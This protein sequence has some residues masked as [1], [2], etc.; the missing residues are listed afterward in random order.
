MTIIEL[1]KSYHPDFASPD[2]APIGAVEVDYVEP[3]SFGLL[4]YFLPDS[5][6]FIDVVNNQFHPSTVSPLNG[7]PAFNRHG[8]YID[9]STDHEV[10]ITPRTFNS[11]EE[12]TITWLAA[13]NSSTSS[14][15]MFIG[16]PSVSTDFIWMNT[17]GTAIQF[18]RN[19]QNQALSIPSISHDTLIWRSL[20]VQFARTDYYAGGLSAGGGATTQPFDISAIAAGFST[21][22]FDFD[23]QL[24][25]LM[26]HDRPL[27]GAEVIAL[28]EN[29]YSLLK[30]VQNPIYFTPSGAT[31]AA[32]TGTAVPTIT[33]A[34][35]VAGGKTILIT[36]T[37]DTWVAAGATFDAQRQ[38]I[39]NGLDAAASPTNGWNNEV[40]DKEVVTAVVRT[41]STLVTITLTA[42]AGYD[43]AATETITTTIPATAL[44][45]SAGAI[46]GSPTFTVTAVS[47][48]QAAWARGSNVI[49]QVGL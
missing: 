40:R 26:I 8:R 6:S 16:K 37:G 47:G 15:G 13:K 44:V 5:N 38:N 11:G 12:Y 30:P 22:S 35:V 49:I 18:R 27:S 17:S 3:L 42:Q 20:V 46:T 28:H 7:V 43:V 32:I 25:G 10:G 4:N 21:S 24:Q 33:E 9:C 19:N 14:G 34:D 23:G 39:I 1:D 45:T 2:V 31:T 48:F 41:S 29:P 36:L